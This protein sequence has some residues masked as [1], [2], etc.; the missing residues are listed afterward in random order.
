MIH[1]ILQTDIELATRLRDDQRS[2]E[3]VIRALVYRG[4]DRGKAAQLMDDL[5]SGRKVTAQSPLPPELNLRRRSRTT[6]TASETGERLPPRS[7]E[8]QPRSQPALSSP[9]QGRK[10]PRPSWRVFLAL[11]AL[12]IG[13]VAFI[14]F[15][16]H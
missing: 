3:E 13:V 10:G 9:H 4:V 11:A 2:D 1:D 16:R 14:L 6:S 8:A 7:S 5:R 15:Q 12:A